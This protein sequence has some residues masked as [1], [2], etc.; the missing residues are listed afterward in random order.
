MCKNCKIVRVLKERIVQCSDT[1]FLNSVCFYNTAVKEWRRESIYHFIVTS[2]QTEL[3]D[4][5]N[6]IVR[7]FSSIRARH[8]IRKMQ[9]GTGPRKSRQKIDDFE[10]NGVI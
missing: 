2:N 8:L 1:N 7:A 10:V 6:A 4:S 3:T 9:G 5:F